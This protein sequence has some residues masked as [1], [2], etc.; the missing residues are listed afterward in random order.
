M[1]SH[2]KENSAIIKAAVIGGIFTIV[3]ACIG[4]MFLFLTT[5][6]TNGFV[7]PD[8]TVATS[9]QQDNPSITNE[10]TTSPIVPTTQPAASSGNVDG[11]DVVV[12]PR[13]QVGPYWGYRTELGTQTLMLN[14]L[15]LGTDCIDSIE[16]I[17]DGQHLVATEINNSNDAHYINETLSFEGSTGVSCNY[18]ISDGDLVIPSDYFSVPTATYGVNLPPQAPSEWCYQGSDKTWRQC[19]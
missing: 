7:A 12:G 10:P 1:A 6:V 11:G 2:S 17:V 8:P 18:L 5:L 4:G 13:I 3:A 19:N 9:N 16:I 15:T 14:I